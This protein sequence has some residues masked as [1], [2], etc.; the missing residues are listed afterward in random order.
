M[1]AYLINRT[2]QPYEARPGLL[3][4]AVRRGSFS[5]GALIAIAPVLTMRCS[6]HHAV[7]LFV[8][9]SFNCWAYY[10]LTLIQISKAMATGEACFLDDEHW[11]EV[12]FLSK[13]SA[14]IPDNFRI[15]HEG[16]SYFA[17]IPGLLARKSSLDNSSVAV[18][19]LTDST[20]HVRLGMIDWYNRLQH[21]SEQPLR[22]ASR[23]ASDEVA[24]DETI[25]DYKDIM[26]AAFTV[27][28]SAY[29]I[30]VNSLLDSL[31]QTSTNREESITLAVD[32]CRSATY[33]SRG[34]F[35]GSQAMLFALPVA[36]SIL[37]QEFSSDIKRWIYSYESL[38]ESR[39]LRWF[40]T[41]EDRANSLRML[42]PSKRD[43]STE[44][45]ISL[46]DRGLQV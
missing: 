6:W 39:R 26:A 23:I 31:T 42:K 15:Y 35:C 16:L 36:L 38:E 41:S 17:R 4:L 8:D 14:L 3:T 13:S 34:G 20:S 37:P 18:R 29:R 10:I 5:Y 21:E 9:S 45:N 12:T 19:Q 2:L 25:Y 33:C 22:I 11:N 43:F 32:I 27:N 24:G 44:N 28:Y 46:P 30:M 1:Y 7:I 40:D